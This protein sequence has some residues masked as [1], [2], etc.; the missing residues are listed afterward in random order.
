MCTHVACV[1]NVDIGYKIELLT[2]P[3]VREYNIY[4]I[5]IGGYLNMEEKDFRSLKG[6][7]SYPFLQWVHVLIFRRKINQEPWTYA[8][9]LLSVKL[10]SMVVGLIQ[11]SKESLA[12]LKKLDFEFEIRL[13]NMTYSIE[14]DISQYRNINILAMSRKDK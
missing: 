13:F 10:F 6:M 1:W 5:S 9:T 8:L 12:V 11:I 3:F 2:Y 4:Y 7:S 14:Y